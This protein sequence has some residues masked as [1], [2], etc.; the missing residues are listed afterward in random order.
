ADIETGQIISRLMP[1]ASSYSSRNGLMNIAPVAVANH[2][3]LVDTIYGGDLQGNIWKFDLSSHN[4]AGWNVAFGGVPLFSARIGS[5][6]QPITGGIEVSS[7]PGGGVSLFFGTG[8]YFAEE[9]RDSAHI[10]S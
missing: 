2:H 9:D 10:Q 3:G 1:A 8:S 4:A 5:Q 7:G 6:I